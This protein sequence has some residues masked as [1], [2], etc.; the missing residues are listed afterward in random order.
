MPKRVVTVNVP[1][2][3]GD[4]F[5]CYQKLSPYY[6]LI[7]I[8]ILVTHTDKVQLRSKN[9]LSVLPKVGSVVVKQVTGVEYDS[10]IA[11]YIPIKRVIQSKRPSNY[12]C[13][14]PLEDG[15]RLED[16]DTNSL[17]EWDVPV[18]IHDCPIEYKEYICLYVS[19]STKNNNLIKDKVIWHEDKWLELIKLLYAKHQLSYPICM[20]GASYD[21]DVVEVIKA[22]LIENGISTVSYI[23]SYPANVLNIIKKSKLFIGY[24]S[25]LNILADNIHVPQLMMYFPFLEKMQYTWCKKE[26]IGKQFQANLFTKSPEEVVESFNLL[27]NTSH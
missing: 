10:V 16:I 9:W 25:G 24:Q 26:H 17:V 18:T 7:N 3:V 20:I 23:D 27:L 12:S 15:I 4:I 19:G 1:Q 14:K 21:K 2:G 5:W 11:S 6:D 22:K 8:N 13:N